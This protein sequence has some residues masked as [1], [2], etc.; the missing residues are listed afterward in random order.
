M[1]PFLQQ[2]LEASGWPAERFG[3]VSGDAAALPLGDA[4]MD[5]VVCTL[6]GCCTLAC[7][8]LCGW[9]V[10]PL[11]AGQHWV[12]GSGSSAWAGNSVR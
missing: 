9:L 5:A 8:L 4:S 12:V 3:W 1:R 6:V 2:N 11:A 7:L 10:Q